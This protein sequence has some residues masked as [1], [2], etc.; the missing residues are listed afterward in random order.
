MKKNIKNEILVKQSFS[1]VFSI[2]NNTIHAL[3][4]GKNLGGKSLI[5][6]KISLKTILFGLILSLL[7][8]Q[9][10]KTSV[11]ETTPTPAPVNDT[12]PL[13]QS[14]NASGVCENSATTCENGLG[15]AGA[16]TSCNAGYS[17]SNGLCLVQNNLILSVNS[18]NMYASLGDTASFTINTD[19]NWTIT[20]VPDWLSVSPKSGVAGGANKITLTTTT[21][22]TIEGVSVTLNINATGNVNLNKTLSLKRTR[23][24]FC[25]STY[26]VVGPSVVIYKWITTGGAGTEIYNNANVQLPNSRF[27]ATFIKGCQWASMG[28]VQQDLTTVRS[29]SLYYRESASG[30]FN[31]VSNLASLGQGPAV[32]LSTNRPISLFVGGTANETYFIME[33]RDASNTIVAQLTPFII[34]F[35]NPSLIF[36][37]WTSDPK[38]K[39]ATVDLTRGYASISGSGGSNKGTPDSARANLSTLDF[40]GSV[41][42]SAFPR[43]GREAMNALLEAANKTYRIPL[44]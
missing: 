27:L 10:A 19:Q 41:S 7:V 2:V 12:C 40:S 43:A 36:T 22:N 9:C 34:L 8:M 32:A 6:A 3:R 11:T 18:L 42:E 33:L 15:K 23:F 37:T 35:E 24:A 39:F 30:N 14:K 5:R 16:C 31:S 17:V 21:I 44:D 1:K 29:A 28:S 38:T 20:G 13:G 4:G 26:G 25:G